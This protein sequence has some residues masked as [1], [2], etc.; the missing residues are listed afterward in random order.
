MDLFYFLFFFWIKKETTSPAVVAGKIFP[1]RGLCCAPV[2][3]NLFDQ[4]FK[5][6][7]ILAPFVRF[8]TQGVVT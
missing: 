4:G 5:V 8:L 7:I 2:T 3:E 6:S 1:A